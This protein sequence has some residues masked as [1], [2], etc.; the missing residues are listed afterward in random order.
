MRKL[1]L[2]AAMTAIMPQAWADVVPGKTYRIVPV[3]DDSKSLFV[4]NSSPASGTT[5]VLWTDTDVPSQQWDVIDNG[6]GTMALRNVYTDGYIV[7]N[8]TVPSTSSKLTQNVT[9]TTATSRWTLTPVDAAANTYRMTQTANN[10]EFCATLSSTTD[11]VNVTLAAPDASKASMQTWKFVEVDAKRSF[12]NEARVRMMNGWRDHFVQAAGSYKTLSR[13]GWGEAEMLETLLD[14][15]E[16]SGN[17]EYLTLF[18]TIFAYFRS[19]VGDDWLRLVY[20]DAYHWFGHDF[21]DDVMWMII[22]SARAYM[23]TGSVTYRDLAKKNFDAIYARAYN[24]WGMMRWAEQSGNHN[25]TNSCINGP[26]EVAACYLAMGLG[27]ESYYDIARSLYDNQRRYLFNAQ[28]GQV[29]DSFTWDAATNTPG[30]Y[31]RWVSTY[32]Q[33]TMLGAA[34]LLYNHYGDEQYR[35]DADAIV[36]CS[37]ND[38]C[39]ANGIIKVCQTVEGDLCGFKGILMRYLRRYAVDFQKADVV[40]WMQDNAMR[41]YC[42]MNSAG[43]THSAW[44]TK[45]AENWM[46]GDKSYSDQPFGCSTAVSAAFNAPLTTEFFTRDAFSDIRAVDFDYTRSLHATTAT[47]GTACLTNTCSGYYA[48]YKRVDF[49]TRTAQTVHAVVSKARAASIEARL[50][51]RL[52]SPT[53]QLIATL[54]V[55]ATGTWNDVEATVAPV[56]GIHDVY[57]LPTTKTASHTS[58]YNIK[59]FRF[60]TTLEP[61]AANAINGAGVVTVSPAADNASALTDGLSTTA[62]TVS[63]RQMTV[64]YVSPTPISPKGYA[65]VASS[66]DASADPAAWT[67]EATNGGQAWTVLDECSAMAFTARC[68]Q[69][70]RAVSTAKQF[71]RFRLTVKSNGGAA[72]TSLAQLMIFGTDVTGKGI[73]DDGGTVKEGDAALTDHDADHDVVFSADG[74]SELT[75]VGK[76]DYVL[77]RYALTSP[78]SASAKAPTAWTLYGSDNTSSWTVIDKRVAQTFPYGGSTQ[79]YEVANDVAYQNYRLVIDDASASPSLS[80]VRLEGA[81]SASTYLYNDITKNGGEFSSSDNA[82]H[83]VL[84]AVADNNPQSTVK[85]PLGTDTWIMYKSAVPT[86]VKQYSVC[87]GANY[88]LTPKKWTLQVSNDGEKWQTASTQN[89][90]SFTRSG[91]VR[92]YNT[93]LS[94]KYTY[95]RLLITA[96]QNASASEVEIGEWQINGLCVS[97]SDIV[98]KGGTCSAERVGKSSAEDCTSLFDANADTKYCFDFYGSAWIDYDL[99][100]AARVNLYSLTSASDNASRDPSAWQLLGSDDGQ[101]WTLLDERTGIKFQNRKTTQFFS[102]DNDKAYAHYRLQLTANSGD[103]QGQISEWQMFYSDKVA[104]AIDHVSDGSAD[105]ISIAYDRASDALAVS[106]DSAATVAVYATD[107][108][109][110]VRTAVA[111]GQSKVSMA[112]AA[113]GVYVVKVTSAAGTKIVKLTK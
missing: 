65:L 31:N 62:V 85:L 19:Q 35:H 33:G 49:G 107:G 9:L 54:D 108:T 30:G 29:F 81:L 57:I 10:G 3:A 102:F 103:L 46:Y 63:G 83:D 39:D 59:S 37:R 75:Y 86:T 12:D 79:Y 64:E 58:A 43:V 52:D 91:Q 92:S 27:D 90:A 14:A 71:S 25:G 11:G 15:Y 61:I 23:L 89:S 34:V 66:G 68:S 60:G 96:A 111:A 5:V 106:A 1:I 6:D 18:N 97:S 67:L 94:D 104:T 26:T 24:Q 8:S 109:T 41:A 47:D 101:S 87:S 105:G 74:S 44:L 55:P 28:T 98:S 50:E 51:V 32:N 70:R 69:L 82:A 4:S 48:G 13:G 40:A 45:S 113:H 21:N 80:E 56:T 76:G 112:G 84:K 53:G 16:T 42:N 93:S 22:A 88:T 100:A 78:S 73:T 72:T 95:F 2:L 99:D 110:V 7:R 38:L 77:A 20:T 17:K 36:S